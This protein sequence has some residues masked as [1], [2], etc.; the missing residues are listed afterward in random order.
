MFPAFGT[1]VAMSANRAHAVPN[2]PEGCGRIERYFRHQ[3]DQFLTNLDPK[4]PLSLEGLNDRLRTWIETAYNRVEHSSLN[5]TPLQEHQ[6][7]LDC[8]ACDLVLLLLSPRRAGRHGSC[9]FE[10]QAGRP[11]LRL[12]R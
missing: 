2:R 7:R 1:A 4:Q 8:R 9:R 11:I 6:A 10:T 12:S 3:R 5:S